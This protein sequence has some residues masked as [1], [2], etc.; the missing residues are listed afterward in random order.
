MTPSADKLLPAARKALV[1]IQSHAGHAMPEHTVVDLL[2]RLDL[3]RLM[4]KFAIDEVDSKR[5]YL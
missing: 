1:A 2:K 5:D 3:I 4:A